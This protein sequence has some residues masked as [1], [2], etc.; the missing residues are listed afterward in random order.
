MRKRELSEKLND[1]VKGY[2]NTNNDIGIILLDV[3][4]DHI[5]SMEVFIDIDKFKDSNGNSITKK[6]YGEILI[7]ELCNQIK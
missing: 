3:V 2:Y 6:Q 4:K 5:M 7:T 1:I